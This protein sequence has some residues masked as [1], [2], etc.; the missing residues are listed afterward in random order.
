MLLGENE[1]SEGNSHT[2]LGIT[3]SSD[4]SWDAHIVRIVNK[5]NKR[6]ALLKRLKFKL[7]RKTL[8]KLYLTM[9]RP[10]LE[11]GCVI[12]DSGSNRLSDLEAVQ[13]EAARLCTGA[14][15]H[16]PRG[17]VLAELGWPTLAARRKYYKLM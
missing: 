9:I 5:A 1:I 10:I 4:L 8:S 7:S 11:Y 6:L 16:T 15:R 12:F 3:L 17:R 13:T 14:L 2:Y